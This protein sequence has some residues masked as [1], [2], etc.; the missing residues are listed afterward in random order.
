MTSFLF[1]PVLRNDTLNFFAPLKTD[2]VF[3]EQVDVNGLLV[4]DDDD[5]P[6]P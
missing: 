6:P 1:M 5:D 3:V 2:F 4:V